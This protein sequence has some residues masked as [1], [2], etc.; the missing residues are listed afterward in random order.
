[1]SAFGGKADM[2][3]TLD[4]PPVL[5]WPPGMQS[6]C[7]EG[8]PGLLFMGHTLRQLDTASQRNR[9]YHDLLLL[10]DRSPISHSIA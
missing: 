10:D 4:R 6:D 2:T 3:R 8:R 9:P 7:L 1:M 5:L